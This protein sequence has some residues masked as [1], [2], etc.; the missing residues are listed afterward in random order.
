MERAAT[1]PPGPPSWAATLLTWVLPGAGHVLLGATRTAIVA[2]L[3]IEGLYVLGF[4]LSSG[5]VNEFLD[6]ELRGRFALVLTPEFGNFGAL[7]THQLIQP[8]GAASAAIAPPRPPSTVHLGAALTA[9]SG[10][11]NLVLMAH[12]HLLSRCA[13]DDARRIADRTGVALAAGWFLPGVGHW[14]QGRARRGAIVLGTVLLLF[15]IGVVLTE[16]TSLSREHHF[17]YWSGQFLTGAP[18]I[19]AEVLRGH[20]PLGEVPAQ[21][22]VGLFYVCLAGLLNA[23]VSID[24]FGWGESKALGLDPVADRRAMATFR[25]ESKK[26]SGEK[27]SGAAKSG[28]ASAASKH[29]VVADAPP[30]AESEAS[31]G[32]GAADTAT[33]DDD[34]A[35]DSTQ[36]GDQR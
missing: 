5:L 13:D 16:G 15:A 22:D 34:A 10:I 7:L 18:A 21:L 33:A 1:T 6:P 26:R 8:L 12:A 4:L 27:K 17:Y 36:G 24:L 25:R 30:T 20:P 11:L 3:V 19:V 9:A 28:G 35:A 2:F 23:L 32:A 29:L 31:S 14:L